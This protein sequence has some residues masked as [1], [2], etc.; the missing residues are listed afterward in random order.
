MP[1]IQQP[2]MRRSGET[3]LV[4]ES[5]GRQDK[6]GKSPRAEHRTVPAEQQSP[7][8]PGVTESRSHQEPTGREAEGE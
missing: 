8:G 1:N 7:Y 3:R 6:A 2:E 4:Q 5:D